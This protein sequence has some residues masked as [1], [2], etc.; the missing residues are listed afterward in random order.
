MVVGT[1]GREKDSGELVFKLV[2]NLFIRGIGGFGHKGTVKIDIPQTPKTAP[3]AEVEETTTPNQAFL[4]RLS[5]DFN[6]LHVDPDMSAVG[7]FKVPILH[8]LCFYGI[9]AKAVQEKYHKDDPTLMTKINARFTGHVFPGE[10]LIVQMW[11]KGNQ[12]IVQTKTKERGTTVLKG[13][14]ELK[15][16]AKL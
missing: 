1:E 6:P 4:Y 9:T 2:T 11:K 10:T 8:G 15:P 14:C 13:V 5:G 16:E 3:D 7:G 12:V